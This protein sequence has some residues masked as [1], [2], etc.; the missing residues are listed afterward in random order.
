MWHSLRSSDIFHIF[1]K[2]NFEIENWL[3]HRYQNVCQFKVVSLV[4]FSKIWFKLFQE[5]IY[6]YISQI[7]LKVEVWWGYCMISLWH[8]EAAIVTRYVK[9]A[10]KRIC[11]L[12]CK[13]TS[14]FSFAFSI[15]SHLFLSSQIH[16]SHYTIHEHFLKSKKLKP[17]IANNI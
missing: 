1:S 14:Y 8:L 10:T 4:H 2:N 7:G 6:I 3:Y 16:N 13:R 5:Y 17:K 9:K 11:I 12:V 15:I